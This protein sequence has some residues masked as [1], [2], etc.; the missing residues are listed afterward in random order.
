MAVPTFDSRTAVCARFDAS[1][2][3]PFIVYGSIITYHMDGVISGEARAWQRHQ[4]SV[5][6]HGD[7]W[8]TLRRDYPDHTIVVAGDY[9]QVL[10][11]V[12]RYRNARST[13][14]LSAAFGAGL[15]CL[16]TENFRVTQGLSRHSVDHIAI[17]APALAKW[18][19]HATAW[20][21]STPNAPK[22]SDHN[23][24]TVTLR[25]F[26]SDGCGRQ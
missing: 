13:E 9:N 24:V 15:V 17:G 21:S 10:D 6:Q 23:G 16:T 5:Q 18:E 20:E 11:G 7:D 4:E 19:P 25:L 22:L 1:P 14:L 26:P 8:R 3:G 2:M 12:G